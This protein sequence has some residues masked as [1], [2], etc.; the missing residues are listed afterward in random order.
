MASAGARDRSET[1]TSAKAQ[2]AGIRAVDV[3]F[4]AP[5]AVPLP[6]S[7]PPDASAATVMLMAYGDVHARRSN[8]YRT[9]CRMAPVVKARLGVKRVASDRLRVG[10]S[11]APP[12]VSI[13]TWLL[14]HENAIGEEAVASHGVDATASS[15]SVSP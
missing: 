4:A 1:S 2:A 8:V 11:V 5:E 12:P 9:P 3:T 13:A 10:A 7:L 14:F 15:V 6:P